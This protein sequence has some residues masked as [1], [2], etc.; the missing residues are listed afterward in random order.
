MIEPQAAVDYEDRG[1]RA[2]YAV[3][4]EL[5]QVL[6]AFRDRFVVIGGAVPWLHFPDADPPHV[7]TLDVDLS[8]D[9]EALAPDDA[10]THLIE[11]LERAGYARGQDGLRAF[12]LKRTFKVDEGEPIAVI[13]DLLMPRE[14]RLTRHKPPLLEQFA[15]LKA[16]GATM[17]MR[18]NV[19]LQFQG[20]M[21]DGRANA[22]GLRVASIPAFLVMKGYAL[23][24][25]D[26]RKDA[27]DIYF[28]V[29][30]FVGGPSSLAQACKP[31]LDDPI[32]RQG[33]EHIRSK[34]TDLEAFGPQTVMQFMR[35]STVMGGMTP[36]QVQQDA[37][38]R[39]HAWLNAMG[40]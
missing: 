19:M 34:F 6:G 14:V 1:A 10:Y 2:V 27:Y 8:L 18:D 38:Q 40:M 20:T 7:G 36:E 11:A 29:R 9:A 22:V 17:A 15:V 24:G 35:E 13:V 21:P 12:Q 25:R 23:A 39:V 33:Y 32:A 3:L 31:L 26:K 5:G 16:D 37:H 28:A 30:E 4:L